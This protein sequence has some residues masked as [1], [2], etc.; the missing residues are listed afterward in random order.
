MTIPTPC[1]AMYGHSARVRAAV[2][3][4]DTRGVPLPAAAPP[5]RGWYRLPAMHRH[6]HR[7]HVVGSPLFTCRRAR[8]TLLPLV[9]TA[10]A[11]AV[12]TIEN[13][14]LATSLLTGLRVAMRIVT[15]FCLL[16]YTT[17]PTSSCRTH[18]RVTVEMCAYNFCVNALTI[19]FSRNRFYNL[20][21]GPKIIMIFESVYILILN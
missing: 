1:V 11:T 18:Q 15:I 8:A 6:L 10:T 17:I 21:A 16:L 13:R 19:T 9:F 3:T 2:W 7:P 4:A 12:A 20:V 5:A 14:W